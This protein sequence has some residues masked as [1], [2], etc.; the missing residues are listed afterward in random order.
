M[1]ALF[2]LQKLLEYS[3]SSP[4]G[5]PARSLL[6]RAIDE[7]SSCKLCITLY[8]VCMSDCQVLSL[9][10]SDQIRSYL[11]NAHTIAHD[12]LV[13]E[14]ER[15]SSLQSSIAST[16]AHQLTETIK[17][18]GWG[19]QMSLAVS[20]RSYSDKKTKNYFEFLLF[21]PSFA[22]SVYFPLL[23]PVSCCPFLALLSE[24]VVQEFES[25]FFFQLTLYSV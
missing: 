4:G 15:E 23:I 11:E 9:R 21:I 19:V 14:R 22:S 20:F 24:F 6:A 8:T 12:N 1:S 5:R 13:R 7:R 17:R 10:L 3:A 18:K 16:R 2:G 25:S